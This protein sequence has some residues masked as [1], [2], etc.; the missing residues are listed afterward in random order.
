MPSVVDLLRMIA[1]LFV[2]L[3]A[4]ERMMARARKL[5]RLGLFSF[6][7][8]LQWMQKRGIL[9]RRPGEDLAIVAAR[10]DLVVWIAHDPLAALKTRVRRMRGW[11]RARHGAFAPTGWGAVRLWLAPMATADADVAFADSS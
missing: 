1:V 8:A 6:M 7:Y 11:K 2:A 10:I 9:L 3:G 5:D 4:P